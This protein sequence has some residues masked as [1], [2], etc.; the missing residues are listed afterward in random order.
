MLHLAPKVRVTRR[1]SGEAF[2]FLARRW[3]GHSDAGGAAFPLEHE[4]DVLHP[5]GGASHGGADGTS[6]ASS[7]S[8]GTAQLYEEPAVPAPAVPL[9]R[10]LTIRTGAAAVPHPDKMRAG[11]RGIARQE[12]GHAGE[13]AYF[14]A[15]SPARRQE[16]DHMR[17]GWVVLG[18]ADGV[19][20]WRDQ[21]IDAGAFSRALCAAAAA[22]ATAPTHGDCSPLR[23]MQTAYREVIAA[24]VQGSCTACFVCV[25]PTDGL[26]R[27][28]NVGDSGYL[29]MTPRRAGNQRRPQP[30]GATQ[31][32][33]QPGG[34]KYRSPHQEHEFGRPYQLG[35]WPNSDK[36]EDAMLHGARLCA[37]DVLVIGTD[38]VW[39]NLH[40]SEVAAAVQAGVD[41]NV[42]PAAI[43]RAV[44]AAAFERSTLKRGSTPYS[45]AASEAH[46]L[47]FSGGKRDDI[48]VIV[49]L[50]DG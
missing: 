46:D 37:G 42:A 19:Y 17:P 4:V 29:L 34:V 32:T 27:S 49:M 38:G 43:A 10:P 30:A 3:L 8:A 48:S 23:L 18:V 25:D 7:V 6:T 50:A 24:G 40:D 20:A 16:G 41:S 45:L 47:V 26:V 44:A 39:D 11:A 13:D 12:S 1:S 2:R 9:T 22:E 5:G 14:V 31:A 15:S 21:G 35:H 33:W 36:P 28:A